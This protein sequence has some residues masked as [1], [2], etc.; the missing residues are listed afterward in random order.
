MSR[1]AEYNVLDSR[2]S[3]RR[4]PAPPCD[5]WLPRLIRHHEPRRHVMTNA[6]VTEAAPPA[7]TANPRK[8]IIVAVHGIGDQVRCE[9]IQSVAVQLCRYCGLSS[10]IPLGHFNAELV[11][12]KGDPPAAAAYLIHG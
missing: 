10:A 8:K 4:N 1:M 6:P 7:Q 5:V 3:A 12:L 9:T 11:Q 2:G